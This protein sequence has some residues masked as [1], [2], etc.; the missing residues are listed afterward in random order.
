MTK[1]DSNTKRRRFTH[2]ADV[3][4]GQIVAYLDADLSLRE[5]AKRMD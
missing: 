3:E 5:I 4:G 2:L 1:T